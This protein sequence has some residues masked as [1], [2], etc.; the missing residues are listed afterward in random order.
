MES[1]IPQI[2]IQNSNCSYQIYLRIYPEQTASQV[3]EWSRTCLP[4]QETQQTW[5]RSLSQEDPL[6]EGM[7]PCSS[8]LAW[9]IPQTEEPGG[10]QSVELQRVEHD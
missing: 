1:N 8:I 2:E 7:A 5:V 9:E 6:E 3:A 10:L 4:V